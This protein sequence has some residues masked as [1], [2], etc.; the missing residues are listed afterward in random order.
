MTRQREQPFGLSVGVPHANWLPVEVRIG[1]H[2]EK[3]DAS[4][5]VSDDPVGGLLRLA[6]LAG[7]DLDGDATLELWIE[8]AGFWLSAITSGA[9][10]SDGEM[11]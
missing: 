8:P 11:T 5:A 4:G 10:A 9:T 3:V 6:L 2:I 1:D 7:S